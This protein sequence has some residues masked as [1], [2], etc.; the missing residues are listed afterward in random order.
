MEDTKSDT[1]RRA[2]T[3]KFGPTVSYTPWLPLILEYIRAALGLGHKICIVGVGSF[4]RPGSEL[5]CYQY[6]E[7]LG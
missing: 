5:Y 1:C 7:G 4:V 2:G 3:F 6:L